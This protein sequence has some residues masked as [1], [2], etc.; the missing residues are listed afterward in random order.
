MALE[1]A[2]IADDLTGGMMIASLL[3]REAVTCPLITDVDQLDRIDP[4]ADAVI[5]ANK[6]RLIP[7]HEA[8]AIVK[9]A[10]LVLR[11][12]GAKRLYYK[13]CAT[14]D[15]TDKGNIGP[16]GEVL[17]DVSG[18]NRMVFCPAFPEYSVTVYQG[19]MFLGP[20]LMSE[21]AKR[22]DPVTPMTDSNLVRV[23]QRQSDVKVGLLPHSALHQ[24]L[25]AAEAAIKAQMASGTRFF[26]VDAV[27]NDDVMQCARLIADWP[28][29]SGADA[30]PGFLAKVWKEKSAK[31]DRPLRHNLPPAT[32]HEVI[33]AGSCAL[34]TL[35]QLDY[36][37]ERHPL[38]R[39]NLLE[40]AEDKDI[41]GRIV[42][43]AKSRI[44]DGPVGV[45]TS[46]TVGNV[47]KI[48]SALGIEEAA[49]L[50]DRI[51]GEV[52]KGLYNL[53]ARR[54]VV[55]GGETAGQVF[56]ALEIK[57]VEV[58]SFD[59]LGGGYCHAEE[60]EPITLLLKAGGIPGDDL[61]LR[62]LDRMRAD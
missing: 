43:W 50:A 13:Y 2:A 55:A 29:A 23:L 8:Q 18:A 27:D 51:T 7:A 37:E 31:P 47:E 26:M 14:F 17:M 12:A 11:K 35:R 22:N 48:Q 16:C 25:Q 39:V 59:D 36:F 54:F 20:T 41:V 57:K 33:L 32:G 24:G 38:Y 58:S 45:A 21:T 61:F 28:C 9:A 56:G 49:R 42:D 40:A 62:G 19:H 10:A 3:E 34:A 53:G 1:L 30:M 6:F 60:P 5:F 4:G 44:T 46:D 52:A 15:S